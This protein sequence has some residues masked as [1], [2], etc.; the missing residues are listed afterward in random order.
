[1]YL[2]LNTC[3]QQQRDKAALSSRFIAY[4]YFRCLNIQNE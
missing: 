4:Y 2:N 1:M 3:N